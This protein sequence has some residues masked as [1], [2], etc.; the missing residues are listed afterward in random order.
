MKDRVA[1]A[2]VTTDGR[3]IQSLRTR[4][5][6]LDGCRSVLLRR[7]TRQRSVVSIANI[8]TGNVVHQ[9]DIHTSLVPLH[10]EAV[11]S[12]A[13]PM[14][15]AGLCPRTFRDSGVPFFWDRLASRGVSSVTLGFPFAAIGEDSPLVEYPFP[16][17][18]RGSGDKPKRMLAA[19]EK[20]DEVVPDYRFAAGWLPL[21][22]AMKTSDDDEPIDVDD[23]DDSTSEGANDDLERVL[24]FVSEFRGRIGVDH[25]VVVLH[26]P[27]YGYLL[28]DGPR[29]DEV[30]AESVLE[31]DV[32]PTVLD[33]LG[34]EMSS[35]IRGRSALASRS[36]NESAASGT[37]TWALD[38]VPIVS[39]DMQRLVEEIGGSD[40]HP[41]RVRVATTYL[42]SKFWS[43]ISDGLMD[44]ALAAAREV[45]RIAPSDIHAFWLALSSAMV[46]DVEQR[47]H[48][49]ASLRSEYPGST[50][51]RMI[52]LLPG[53]GTDDETL[54]AL[55]DDVDP[56]RDL[57][58]ILRGLWGRAAI[59]LGMLD[60]G[61]ETLQALFKAGYAIRVDRVVLGEAY[62]K[63]NAE[64]D[65]KLVLQS[66]STL[67]GVSRTRGGEA[68]PKILLLRCLALSRTGKTGEAISMLEEFLE[69]HP[70]E[71]RATAMLA[72]LRGPAD[73]T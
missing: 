18:Y 36:S 56:S 62:G 52:P 51:T 46:Q 29:S 53:M 42:Q 57:S 47:D 34:E 35:F 65:P 12:A 40:D 64:G 48:A 67:P 39:N 63:R 2:I 13:S 70:L 71:S 26:G 28:V 54:R 5:A 72:D 50:A 14:Q 17:I 21:R 68:N 6:D 38:D 25:H 3:T 20:L 19:F 66:L 37:T 15:A 9:H 22:A 24:R 49:V 61:I 45:A 4:L 11:A 16:A 55:L 44:E 59:R 27:R 60:R 7:P 33:L 41:M 73:V 8:G 23:E 69:N 1:L 43:S 10:H 31:I 30:Q 32:A 58:P